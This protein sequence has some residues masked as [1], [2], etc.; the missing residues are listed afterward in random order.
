MHMLPGAVLHAL[1][2]RGVCRGNI[3]MLGS[4]VA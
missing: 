2:R 4:A 3:V 1:Q